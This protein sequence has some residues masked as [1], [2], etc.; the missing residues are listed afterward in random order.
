MVIEEAIATMPTQNHSDSG[1][2]QVQQWRAG[3]CS[4]LAVSKNEIKSGS[5]SLAGVEKYREAP[6][7]ANSGSERRAED[8]K[9]LIKLASPAHALYPTLIFGGS[10]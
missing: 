10:N 5:L 6:G 1:S 2:Q 7:Y 4:P 3:P 9:E 8:Y